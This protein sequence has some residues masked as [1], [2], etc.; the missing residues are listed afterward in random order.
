MDSVRTNSKCLWSAAL[1]MY[2]EYR[3]TSIQW[4]F[5]TKKCADVK[6]FYMHNLF[7]TYI[8]DEHI[9]KPGTSSLRLTHRCATKAL[10]QRAAFRQHKNFFKYFFLYIISPHKRH[11]FMSR[12]HKTVG[13]TDSFHSTVSFLTQT[14]NTSQL[15]CKMNTCCPP[16]WNN[17]AEIWTHSWAFCKIKSQV[18]LLLLILLL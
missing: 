4:P 15:N 8:V 6:K 7:L 9:M 16:P 12:Q 5:Q 11:A 13:I 1:L 10:A 14:V 2:K 18:Y 3:I 17:C